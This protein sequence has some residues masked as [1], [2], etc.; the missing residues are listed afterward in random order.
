MHIEMNDGIT[1]KE[2]YR[3]MQLITSKFTQEEFEELV[4]LLILIQKAGGPVI[5]ISKDELMKEDTNDTK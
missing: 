5:R 1:N 4:E 3:L 2:K